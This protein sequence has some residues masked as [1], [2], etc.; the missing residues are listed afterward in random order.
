MDRRIIVILLLLFVLLFLI[1]CTS[2]ITDTSAQLK[3]DVTGLVDLGATAKYEAWIMVDGAPESIGKFSVNSLGHMSITSFTVERNLLSVATSCF[4]SIETVPDSSPNH[5][6]HIILAGD[7]PSDSTSSAALVVGHPSAL[8]NNFTAATGKYILS[9]PTDTNTLNETAGIWFQNISSGY[10]A[11]GLILPS[12]P[13]HWKYEAWAVIDGQTLSMGKFLFAYQS[14][15]N[16]PYSG[17]IA[18]PSVPGEDFVNN[19]PEGISQ[20]VIMS[21]K[22]IF[23]TIEPEPD[24]S[25]A[26]FL[27]TVLK[28]SI[29]ANAA[30][31]L[32]YNMTN[33][34]A[35]SSPSGVAIRQ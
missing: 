19:L 10:P 8:G 34:A 23:V 17:S 33:Q 31:H 35:I 32:T 22:N 4:I 28:A 14:D 24:F 29:P 18:P 20:P 5:S 7:F 2:K 1:G 21:G 25:S 12:L 26:P 16:A 15:E 27:L 11:V 9:S 3:F 6:D 30:P 13:E